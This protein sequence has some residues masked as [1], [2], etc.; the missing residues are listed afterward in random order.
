MRRACGEPAKVITLADNGLIFKTSMDTKEAAKAVQRLDN[1]R[2]AVEQRHRISQQSTQG[3]N[4]VVHYSQQSNG[5]IDASSRFRK[6]SS[7]TN[8]SSVIPWKLSLAGAATSNIFVATIHVFCIEKCI[9]AATNVLS[10][11]NYVCRD[12]IFLAW[13]TCF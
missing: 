2:I 9:V 12:K 5:Q 10:R 13:Q 1:V 3:T 11:Q 8:K 6:C 7:Q 4:I